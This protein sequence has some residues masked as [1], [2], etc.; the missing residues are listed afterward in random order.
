MH[1]GDTAPQGEK[2][3]SYRGKQ[4]TRRALGASLNLLVLPGAGSFVLGRKTAGSIQIA[5]ALVGVGLQI[6]G[7]ISGSAQAGEMLAKGVLEA[8]GDGA[9]LPG[10]DAMWTAA[11]GTFLFISSW[12][13]SLVTSLMPPVPPRGNQQTQIG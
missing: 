9:P 6:F 12:L 1:T 2:L 4:W 5:G 11:L 7:V 8:G 13:F 10:G 3:I